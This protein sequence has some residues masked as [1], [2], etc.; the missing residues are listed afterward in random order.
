MEHHLSSLQALPHQPACQGRLSNKTQKI[1]CRSTKMRP[2]S[3]SQEKNDSRRGSRPPVA[4]VNQLQQ[5]KP[6][7]GEGDK[8]SGGLIHPYPAI[9]EQPTIKW[10]GWR[11]RCCEWR[12]RIGSEQLVEL[13]NQSQLEHLPSI[14]PS[15]SQHGRGRESGNERQREM[16]ENQS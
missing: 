7:P 1:L 5:Q 11:G 2:N 12:K 4:E 16:G 15:L 9:I 14:R 10:D 13:E 8:R 6:K 3:G